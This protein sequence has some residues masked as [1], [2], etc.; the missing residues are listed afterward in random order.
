MRLNA[1]LT[2]VGMIMIIEETRVKR[3]K[4]QEIGRI[5]WARLRTV[6]SSISTT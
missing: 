4:W 5:R 1:G 2:Q 6:T 3:E